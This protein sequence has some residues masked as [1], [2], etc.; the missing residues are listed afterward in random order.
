MSLSFADEACSVA[1]RRGVALSAIFSFSRKRSKHTA[2][3]CSGG[4]AAMLCSLMVALFNFVCGPVINRCY[5]ESMDNQGYAS[6]TV[7]NRLRA[8]FWPTSRDRKLYRL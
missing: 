5:R 8:R 7:L 4:I 3:E 1:A 2:N 6:A